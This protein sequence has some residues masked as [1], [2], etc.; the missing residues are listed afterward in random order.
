MGKLILFRDIV[1]SDIN[2]KVN[3]ITFNPFLLGYQ[4][5]YTDECSSLNDKSKQRR[6]RTTFTSNQLNELEKIFLET[7]Y[8]DIYTREEIASK[9]HLTEARVQ[10]NSK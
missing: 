5:K 9:L 1:P 8:P 7:H 3:H 4:L 6:I 2:L 10:V